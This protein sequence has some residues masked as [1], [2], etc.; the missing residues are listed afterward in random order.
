MRDLFETWL[1]DEISGWS[2][3][4]FGAI[5]EFIRWPGDPAALPADRGIGW[6]THR[7]AVRVDRTEGV[8]ALA[9]E[10]PSTK[11][12]RFFRHI[13]F[14]LPE[15]EATVPQCQGITEIGV[16]HAAIRPEDRDMVLFDCGLAQKNV[17]FCVRTRDPDLL[18]SLR[19]NAGRD[20]FAAENSA[21]AMIFTHHPHRISLTA[22]GRVEVFQKIGGPDTGWKSPDGPHTHLLPKLLAARRTHSAN[23]PIPAGWLPVASL[24]PA[25]PFSLPDGTERPFNQA[26]FAHYSDLMEAYRSDEARALRKQLEQGQVEAFATEEIVDADEVDDP[27]TLSLSRFMRHAQRVWELEQRLASRRSAV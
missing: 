10:M 25:S 2:M 27:G 12:D 6:F 9:W 20:Y 13:E 7:G 24:H 4:S 26:V 8:K 21:A 15:T 23:T 3:G 19:A 1:A 17:R 11:S 22:I 5:S 14:L 18:A 16:D